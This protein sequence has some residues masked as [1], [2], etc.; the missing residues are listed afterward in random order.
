GH[1]FADVI[2]ILG[3]VII[4]SILGVY[5]ES[6][7][8]KA[9]EALQAISAATT[10]VMRDGKM[11]VVKSEELV[12]G[13]V[14]LLEAGDSV[15][16]DARILESDSLKIEEAALTGESVPVDKII[17]VL[18]LGEQKDISLGDQKNMVYMGSTVV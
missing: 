16:A 14:I 13:D 10:R 18:N 9:I 3:V 7:A 8:E 4:N 6:K 11:Q 2:I 15:P 12:I 5:Q 17:N 1:S